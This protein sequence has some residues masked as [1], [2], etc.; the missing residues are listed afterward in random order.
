LS[1][2]ASNYENTFPVKSN[3]TNGTKIVLIGKT[4]PDWILPCL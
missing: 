1:F 2:E 3:T 4:Q